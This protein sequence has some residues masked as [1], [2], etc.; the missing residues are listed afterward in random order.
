MGQ[1]L[2]WQERFNIGVDIIDKEHKKLF[3]II[4]RLFEAEKKEEKSKW[5][6]QEGIKYFKEHAIRHF[7]EEETYMASIGYMGFE[8]HRRIH[9]D[10]RKKTLP[11]LEKELEQT[12]YS[13]EA[14]SHFLGVCAGWLIGHTLTEDHAITGKGISKWSG[15]LP[16]NEQAVMTKTIAKT[17]YE[18]LQLEPK[19]ISES[20]GG[21]KF[22]HGIYYRLSYGGNS[23]ERW[24]T[25]LVFE[26]KL[27]INTLGSIIDAKADELS[28]LVINVVRYAARQFVQSIKEHF[29]AAD[30]DEIKE[31]TL[32]N[33]DQFQ[34]V[35]EE[36]HPQ[37]SVLFDTGEGYFAYCVIAPHL[38]I[39]ESKIGT[40][41][42]AE[43]AMDEIQEYLDH[44]KEEA[45]KKNKILVVDDSQFVQQAMKEL[46][47]G[48]YDISLA[49]SGTA[50]I[51]CIT[52]DRPDLV[53]LDYEM[54]IC[55]GSQVLEMIRAEKEFAD[56][57]VIFLTSRVDKESV[58]KVI[59]LKPAGYFSKML[60][61]EEVKKGIDD[62]FQQRN[63]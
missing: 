33:Y 31:E 11:A 34:A 10:F 5:K 38:V 54:P 61:P 25:M 20:Y 36:H 14:V 56:I 59:A 55:D 7:S 41:I 8:T 28:V 45:D 63:G 39:G 1:Q 2:V 29:P 35:F 60:Q 51:R 13:E 19:I 18:L 27:I 48:S 49:S 62:F 22:G 52:L 4:N 42:E 53:L 40:T 21:E 50:A 32:L 23:E 58:K 57:P 3:G 24:E 15:L 6:I 12:A 30:E 17:V 47:G 16:E 43:N 44:N 9:D 26:E 46:L 37:Y